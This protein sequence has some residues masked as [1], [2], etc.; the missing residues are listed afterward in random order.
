MTDR[1]IA[2][3]KPLIAAFS[4]LLFAIF[5]LI[6][7]LGSCFVCMLHDGAVNVCLHHA[8]RALSN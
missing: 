7:D 8:A 1:E 2:K 3:A 5:M 4:V 6:F